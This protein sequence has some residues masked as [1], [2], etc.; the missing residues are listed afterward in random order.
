MEVV[1]VLCTHQPRTETGMPL[2]LQNHKLA[3]VVLAGT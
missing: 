2:V 3:V 1:Q